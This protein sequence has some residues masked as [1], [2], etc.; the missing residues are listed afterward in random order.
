MSEIEGG[1]RSGDRWVGK[2]GK[3]EWDLNG[4]GRMINVGRLKDQRRPHPGRA[5]TYRDQ[6]P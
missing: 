3:N 5:Q 2:H 1:C 6:P 4:E